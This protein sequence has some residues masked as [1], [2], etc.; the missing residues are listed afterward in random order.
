MFFCKSK[1]HR[2][3][4]INWLLSMIVTGPMLVFLLHCPNVNLAG[5]SQPYPN[6][7]YVYIMSMCAT[8]VFSTVLYQY[9]V[10]YDVINLVRISSI[11]Q[12]S[13]E[14]LNDSCFSGCGCNSSLFQP[15]CGEDNITYFSP[16]T[17][18]CQFQAR[19][20]SS[21]SFVMTCH[22]IQ[23]NYNIFLCFDN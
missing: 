22:T 23:N 3:A 18:G 6:N 14:R 11:I 2:A 13:T 20:E 10:F 1:G 7:G 19:N 16:C 8:V 21:V 12:S 9:N 5:I 15:V 17:A 4:L